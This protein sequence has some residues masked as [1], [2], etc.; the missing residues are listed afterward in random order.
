MRQK[1]SQPIDAAGTCRDGVRKAKAHLELNLVGD[2]QGNKKVFC[3]S[4]Q[5]QRED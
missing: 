2:I 1:G 3:K 5:K 4:S